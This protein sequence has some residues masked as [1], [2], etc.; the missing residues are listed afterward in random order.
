M[1]HPDRDPRHSLWRKA[2]GVRV[3]VCAGRR[4][5]QTKLALDFLTSVDVW[6][7]LDSGHLWHAP[8][9]RRQAPAVVFEVLRMSVINSVLLWTAGLVCVYSQQWVN[10]VGVPADFRPFERDVFPRWL[11]RFTV[12]Y[13]EGKFSYDP[14]PGGKPSLYG[15]ID[16]IHVLDSVGL[17]PALN[18]SVRDAWKATLDSYQDP[19]TGFYAT[20]D[21]D[22][23]KQPYHGAG[24]ATASLAIIG[25]LPRYNNS[26]Y[27]SLA[28]AGVRA[29]SAF[30]DPLYASACP[31]H[32]IGGNNIHACGQ[33][34]GSPPSVLSYTTRRAHAPFIEWWAAWVANKTDPALGAVCPMQ[35]ST[36][37]LYECIGGAM[38]T[39]GIEEGLAEYDFALSRPRELLEFALRMQMAT[40]AW[41]DDPSQ[42]DA[43]GSLTL[44]GIVQVTRSAKQLN[45]THSDPRVRGACA[46]L[47]TLSASR[48]NDANYVLGNYSDTSHGLPNVLAAV[49]ECAQM[50]PSLVVTD[51][52]WRCCARYV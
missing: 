37:A 24:E 1:G 28:E 23:G 9:S 2:N 34:I 51:H 12:D 35:N 50:F 38:P 14:Q 33:I 16:V 19:D 17:A 8:P 15:I 42:P 20:T 11:E 13:T 40:G 29:W 3:C 30:F 31:S 7:P 25:R 26:V 21:S 41:S 5:R 44:D 4:S 49:G 22:P 47:V 6:T 39:N 48:L 46:R 45:V 18:E 10:P 52:P 36:Y 32:K 27:T 43:L